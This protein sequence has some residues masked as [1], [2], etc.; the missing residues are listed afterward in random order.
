M[1][2]DPLRSLT[3]YSQFIA[4]HLNPHHK[5]VPPNIK[6]KRIPAPGLSFVRPN[7]IQIIQEV[8][9]LIQRSQSDVG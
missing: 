5:H 6:R 4:E 8:E 9:E 7:L 3:A 2:G 1:T